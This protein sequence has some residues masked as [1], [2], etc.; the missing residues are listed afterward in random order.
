MPHRAVCQW[1]LGLAV[2]SLLIGTSDSTVRADTYARQPG[3]DARHYSVRLTLLTNDSN[4]IQGEATV[5]LRVVAAGTREAI[6]DLT[7]RTADGKGMTVT[8]IGSD[9]RPVAIAHRDNRLHLPIPAGATPGQ[10]VVFTITY[11]GAPANGLRLIDNIHGDRTAFS[12]NWYN[13][14]RQWLPMIDHPADKATGE[15]IVTTKADYQVVSNGVIVEQVDLPGGLRRT[16]WKQDVPISSWLYSLGIARFIVRQGGAVR[17]TPLS[18]WAFPQDTDKGLAA[19][20]R[21]ARESFEFFSERVGPYAYAKL[22][23]VEAAGMGGGTEHVSNIFY[24]EKQ[25][26]AGAVPVVHETAH[27][28]FGDSVTE[29]DWNDVWLSEGFATYFT[30][31]YTEHAGGR[32]AFTDGLRRSRNGVLR[33]EKSIPNTPVVHANYVTDV[34]DSEPNNRLVYEKGSWTLHM[35]RDLI[36][37][38]QFWRGIR[39]YYQRHMNGLATTTDL[40]RAMEEVSGTDLGWFFTQWL[41]RAGVPQVS[42]TWHYDASTKQIVVTVK[43]SQTSEPYRFA[44]GIGVSTIGSAIPTVRQVQVTDRESTFTFPAEAEPASVVLDPGVWL[45]AEF[46]P[47][48]KA[49]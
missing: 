27:Q 9:G 47:F 33:L 8:G 36:G 25:V 48:Q 41:T 17:G 10:D 34:A 21:D 37:T 45:L 44:L 13:R 2:V 30:L 11:H 22:A 23:H 14:A 29:S 42:G 3:I 28:W 20:A 46:G 32:D 4:E 31:L 1:S 26:N 18:F 39:L 19:L 24:G 12:E 38:E 7:S 6:L 16:H 35:L 40:R 49:S 5:T 43:Q 15:L